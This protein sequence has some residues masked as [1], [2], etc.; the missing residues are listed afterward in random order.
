MKKGFKNFITINLSLKCHHLQIFHQIIKINLTQM[1]HTI[2]YQITLRLFHQ[3]QSN[4][5]WLVKR[6]ST[7]RDNQKHH[8]SLSP[9]Y[10]SCMGLSIMSTRQAMVMYTIK[11]V[12]RKSLIKQIKIRSSNYKNTPQKQYRKA[13]HQALK[14]SLNSKTIMNKNIP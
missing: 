4:H 6:D 14:M 8:S 12:A 9:K 10:R 7:S 5:L 3:I 11:K 1:K 13:T 2:R